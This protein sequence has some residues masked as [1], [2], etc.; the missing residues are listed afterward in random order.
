MGHRSEDAGHNHASGSVVR[1]TR[2]RPTALADLTG[3]STSYMSL[4]A[5]GRREPPARVKLAIARAIGMRVRDLWPPSD[6]EALSA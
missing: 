4:I 1:R 5:S 2:R 3:Y 6:R